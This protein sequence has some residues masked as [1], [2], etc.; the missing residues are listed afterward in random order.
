MGFYVVNSKRLPTHRTFKINSQE[1]KNN[2]ITV[3]YYKLISHWK[4]K[5][6]H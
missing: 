1:C 5:F 4:F 3:E 2:V 6:R